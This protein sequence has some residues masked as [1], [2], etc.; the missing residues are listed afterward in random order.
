MA[1]ATGLWTGAIVTAVVGVFYLRVWELGH[2]QSGASDRER[3]EVRIQLLQQQLSRAT[4]EE[5]RLKQTIA[6][7]QNRLAVRE[8]IEARRQSRPGHEREPLA[9]PAEGDRWI[10]D[11]VRKGD[12][13]A[14]PQLEQAAVGG[15]GLALDALALLAS[16]DNGAALARVWSATGLSDA[17]RQ[18]A[19]FLLAATVELSPQAEEILQSLFIAPEPPRRLCEEA[20]AGIVMPNFKTK[21]LRDGEI[22]AAL[23][24]KPEYALRLT[25]VEG[26]RAP[27][28][29]AQ[30]LAAIERVHSR[31]VEQAAGEDGP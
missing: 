16:Q 3:L 30:L 4:V 14:L 1:F 19:T 10:A 15:S 26:W 29:D 17:A 6:E 8:A 21:L 28:T 12:A 13:Q 18:R 11:A 7:L 2:G 31:L 24:F 9:R 27:V 23:S 22:P 25:L 20:L 5:Q